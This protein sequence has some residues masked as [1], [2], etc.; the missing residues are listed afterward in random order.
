MNGA[1]KNM[2]PPNLEYQKS[3][4]VDQKEVDSSVEANAGLTSATCGQHKSCSGSASASATKD[5]RAIFSLLC[6]HGLLRDNLFIRFTGERFSHAALV[7][8]RWFEANPWMRN[9][10]FSYDVNCKLKIYLEVCP[11]P[12]LTRRYLETF[13]GRNCQAYQDNIYSFDA[14][15]C[16][17]HWLSFEVRSKTASW[18]RSNRIRRDRDNMEHVVGCVLHGQ[19]GITFLFS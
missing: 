8:S 7:L 17:R 10:I 18:D 9:V 2:R 11:F 5:Q 14:C 12:L 1:Q 16:T 15:I 13:P 19:K 3:L 4:I 6:C